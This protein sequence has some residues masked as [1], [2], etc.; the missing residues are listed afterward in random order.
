MKRNDQKLRR[1]ELALVLSVCLSLFH[2]V[3]LG[4]L[5]GASWWGVIFPGLTAE[6]VQTETG[7][8]P[9]GGVEIR[10]RL[11]DWLCEVFA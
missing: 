7:A 5:Q 6:A 2:G 11:L 8:F 10:F 1:W 9:G 3:S 4:A